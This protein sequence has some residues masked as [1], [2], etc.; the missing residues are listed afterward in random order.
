MTA[1]GEL[2][3]R[4]EVPGA[5]YEVIVGHGSSSHLAC[6]SPV[7]EGAE[8]VFVISDS[9]LADL[10]AARTSSLDDATAPV[11][12]IALAPGESSKSLAAVERIYGRLADAQ[13]HRHDVVVAFGGGVVTD[14]AGF[15][16]ST[17]NR[18]MPLVNVPT[19]LLGQVDAAIGGKT[20]VNLPQGKNLIGTIYQPTAVVCDVGLLASLPQ[21]EVSSGLAEVVK[22]GFIARPSLLDVVEQEAPALLVADPQI[23]I[24]VV[25]QC[26]AIKAGVV[27]RDERES[28]ERANLNYGHT[29]AHA[30]ERSVGYGRLRHGEAVALGMMAAAHLA[31]SMGMISEEVVEHHR[32]VLTAVGLPVSISLEERDLAEAWRH[33]KKYRG[34]VRFV[35]LEEQPD[36]GVVVRSGVEAPTGALDEAIERLGR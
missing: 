31:R 32:R 12:R 7:F 27:A 22:Y 35:L 13:A 10:A 29:F 23:L 14:V 16:A 30:L 17:F 28:G 19:T 3:V 11:H 6:V 36:K 5:P 21:R 20:G 34:G 2:R 33:D 18:G 8:N 9:D 4:V 26:V 15:V 25:G 24:D 1:P